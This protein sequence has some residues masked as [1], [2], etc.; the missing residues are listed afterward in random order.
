VAPRI[1]ESVYV[2]DH[3]SLCVHLGEHD[4]LWRVR[5][6][7][8]LKDVYKVSAREGARLSMAL[9]A[10]GIVHSTVIG[11]QL[12]MALWYK[13]VYLKILTPLASDGGRE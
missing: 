5:R 4:S 12:P 8:Y 10:K 13:G 6:S 7:V 2:N 3:E 9:Q 1:N 11:S